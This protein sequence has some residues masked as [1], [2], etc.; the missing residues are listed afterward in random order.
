MS[1]APVSFAARLA[2]KINTTGTV[3]CVGIDPHPS[4]DASAIWRL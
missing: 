2:N 3:L 4:F 1:N